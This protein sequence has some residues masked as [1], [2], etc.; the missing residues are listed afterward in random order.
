MS[1]VIFALYKNKL[2][3]LEY[4][5]SIKN[6]ETKIN[7]RLQKLRKSLNLNQIEFAER[8]GLTS[9]SIS[10]IESG[11]TIITEQ[12]IRF[13]CMIFNTSE[14]WLRNGTGEMFSKN[15]SGMDMKKLADCFYQLQPETRKMLQAYAEML[16]KNEKAIKGQ[17]EYIADQSVEPESGGEKETMAG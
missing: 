11:K 13:I 4:L 2:Q 5:I 10:R 7:E 6:M 15:V 12:N 17:S 14:D 1:N 3:F 16:L 9:S 8:V